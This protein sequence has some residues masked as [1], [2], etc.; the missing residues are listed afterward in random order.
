[1]V[2]SPMFSMAECDQTVD[3]LASPKDHAAAIATVAAAWAAVLD[4]LFATEGYTAVS[5]FTGFDF[6]FRAIDKHDLTDW[7]IPKTTFTVLGLISRK[8]LASG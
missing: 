4:V 1:M 6:N 5:T 7:D 8:A 3:A 2:G